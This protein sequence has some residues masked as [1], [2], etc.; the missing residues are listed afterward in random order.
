MPRYELIQGS[1]VRFWEIE[2]AGTSVR[3]RSGDLGSDGVWASQV[4]KDAQTA[5]ANYEQL[6]ASSVASGYRVSASSVPGGVERVVVRLEAGSA[7]WR[8]LELR[9]TKL[10]QRV[11]ANEDEVQESSTR[12]EN[13]DEAR[14]Q[15]SF[16]ISRYLKQGFKE[17]SRTSAAPAIEPTDSALE[18]SSH[19]EYEAA[20]LAARDELRPWQIYADWLQEQGD[21]RGELAGLF[22]G[23][24]AAAAW[25]RLDSHR[26]VLV[27]PHSERELFDFTVTNGFITGATLERAT[28]ESR[29]KLDALTRDFLKRPGGCFVSE[30]K[31]GLAGFRG[32]NDWTYTVKALCAAPQ[33]K[34]LRKLEFND[35]DPETWEL[36]S[37]PFGDFSPIW[38]GLPSLEYFHLRAG[39]AGALGRIKHAKL[40]TLIRESHALPLDEVD[41]LVNADCPALERLE[42]WLGWD[43]PEG[44]TLAQFEELLRGERFPRLHH[45]GLV[46]TEFTVELVQLLE[47]SRLLPQLRVLNVSQGVLTDRDAELLLFAA[48]KFAHLWLDL[49]ENMFS[50]SVEELQRA[51]PRAVLHDQRDEADRY[52]AVGE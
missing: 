14:D 23:G 27:G 45:L 19:P 10:I 26:A 48:P 43:N 6:V 13:F 12:F 46:N 32:R 35:F 25:T 37:V 29:T 41:A 9:G 39:G 8:E 44:A 20:C 11:R 47:R 49:S 52:D 16:L 30:L 4:F 1:S 50:E 51:F 33:A 7:A 17:V 36:S 40:K 21:V 42:L 24:N 28:P 18:L 3:M 38:A 34:E 2:L 5:L 31:F 22:L 15:F